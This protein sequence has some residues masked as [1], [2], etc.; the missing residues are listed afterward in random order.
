MG[1]W[2]LVRLYRLLI[3]IAIQISDEIQGIR[4]FVT[5][6]AGVNFF[7]KA[8]N[9]A[10]RAFATSFARVISFLKNSPTIVIKL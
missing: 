1:E 7:I 9:F 6:T 4:N 3:F 10:L 2:S 8:I 5:G